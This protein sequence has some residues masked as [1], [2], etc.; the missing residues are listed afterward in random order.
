M[1]FKGWENF[2]PAA[3]RKDA[4]RQVQG[5]MNRDLGEAL[6]GRILAACD[7]YRIKGLADIEK[8]PEPFK[9]IGGRHQNPAGF[10]VFE[11]VFTKPAQP[12]FK[13]TLQEGRSVV[14]EAK[15]TSTDRMEQREVTVEQERSLSSHA[16]LGAVAFV[17]VSLSLRAFYRVPWST[18]TSMKENYGRKYM[19][20]EDL[21]QYCIK[22]VGGILR[23]LEN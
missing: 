22:E 19:T 3:T 20:A 11:G 8:T 15:A 14:F 9:V 18:W 17:I 23:F 1:G 5:H 16:K 12:D 2:D 13:G 4:R 10:W 7:F 21:A 6:E